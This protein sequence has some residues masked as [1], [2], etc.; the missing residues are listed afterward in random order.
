MAEFPIEELDFL[1][2]LALPDN[3]VKQGADL[4]RDVDYTITKRLNHGFSGKRGTREFSQIVVFTFLV[5]L[6]CTNYKH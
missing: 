5:L 3:S 1:W 2:I 6:L 4:R